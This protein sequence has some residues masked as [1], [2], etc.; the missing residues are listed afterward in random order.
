V[1]KSE[2]Q[3][4]LDVSGNELSTP[5]P[6]LSQ[7]KF[8]KKLILS[9]NG[10]ETLWNLPSTLEQLNLSHNRINT[11]EGALGSQGSLLILNINNNCLSNLKGVELLKKLKLLNARQN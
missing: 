9:N 5:V 4:E 3:T 2:Y 11:L 1:F 10:I 6:E 7:L 8:L